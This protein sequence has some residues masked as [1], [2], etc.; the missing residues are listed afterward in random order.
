MTGVDDVATVSRFAPPPRFLV[1][2]RTAAGCHRRR[3]LFI[4]SPR[5]G[6][7]TRPARPHGRLPDADVSGYVASAIDQH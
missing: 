3:S 2:R 4:S 1:T 5:P 6:P 7:S